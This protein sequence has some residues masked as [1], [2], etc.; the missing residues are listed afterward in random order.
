[1]RTFQFEGIRLGEQNGHGRKNTEKP[2]KVRGFYVNIS[3]IFHRFF[4]CIMG[5]RIGKIITQDKE[6]SK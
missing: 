2:G 5:V 1:M 4:T 6:A 3:Y